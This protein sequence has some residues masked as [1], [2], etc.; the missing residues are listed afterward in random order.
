MISEYDK[1]RKGMID[2]S[3]FIS[4]SSCLLKEQVT[5]EHLIESFKNF[6]RKGDGFITTGDLHLILVNLDDRLTAK[7]IDELVRE[8]DIENNNQINYEKF[9]RVMMSR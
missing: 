5:E 4:L 2:F 1:D 6:D 7:E 9:V 8:A 3:D